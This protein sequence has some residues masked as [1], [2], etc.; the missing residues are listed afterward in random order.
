MRIQKD[1]ESKYRFDID[2]KTMELDKVSE[3]YFET[4]RLYELS[5][6]QGESQKLEYDKIIADLRRRHTEEVNDIVA[7]NHKLQ[8]RIE[9]AGKHREQQRQ[10]R[11]DVDDLKRRLSEAQSEGLDLRK[12]RDQLKID[13]NELLIKNAK[14][15][16]EERNH[17][18]VLQTENDKLRFQIKCFEDDLSKVQLKCERKSQEVQG[19]LSEKTSLLTVLKEKEIMIDSIGRQLSQTKEDLHL[20]EQELDAY[21]RR[22]VAEDKDKSL[23]ERKEKTRI[24]KEL[25][26]LERNYLELVHQRK[27]DLQLKQNDLDIAHKEMTTLE[28]KKSKLD[29]QVDTL[30]NENRDLKK[31]LM[32]KTDQHEVLEKEYGKVQDKYRDMQNAE[33]NLSTQKE[34]QDA[35]M[36]I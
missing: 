4:K 18:R 22:A 25:E 6:T 9:D 35:T 30:E 24:H 16:E 19:A 36:K 21:V 14:D 34:Q 20:K 31:K 12:Q 10:L 5:K 15:V 29:G 11:R 27:A 23:I 26:T 1:L 2:S 3:N 28:E 32:G 8:M 33:F 7:D 13:K 17:R